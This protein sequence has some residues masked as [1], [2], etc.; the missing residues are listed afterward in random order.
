M[1]GEFLEGNQET[2]FSNILIIRIVHKISR[3]AFIGNETEFI[4]Q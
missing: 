2:L 1:L 4:D 3:K